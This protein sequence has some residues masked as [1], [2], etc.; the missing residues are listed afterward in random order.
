MGTR[1]E[2]DRHRSGDLPDD[3]FADAVPVVNAA[4]AAANA[5]RG[6]QEA[7]VGALPWLTVP[8]EW[9]GDRP[10]TRTYLLHDAPGPGGFDVRGPGMLPRGKVAMLAAAGGVGKTYALCGL[11]LSLVTRRP[12]LSHFP[13]GEDLRRRV[14][15]VLG[16][17]DPDEVRRRLYTQAHAMGLDPSTHGDDVAGILALPGVGL[18]ALALTRPKEEESTFGPRTAFAEGLRAYLEAHAGTGWDAVILDPLSRFAGPDVEVDN[19]AATRLIQVLEGFTKLPGGP[20]V[21]LAHHTNK[22]SRTVD[23]PTAAT[24]VRG[25]S[26]LVDGARWV[27]NLEDVPLPMG[28][29]LPG[30]ARFRVTKSNYGTFPKSYTADGLLL[31][32]M[33]GGL[34]V[35]NG[36]E[37]TALRT[38]ELE[39]KRIEGEKGAQNKAARAEGGR[40]ASRTSDDGL[41]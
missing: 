27:A 41:A 10:P 17:E 8:P 11:A 2:N 6:K 1:D 16:E 4:E 20:A 22:A 7:A 26:A 14:V 38:A 40:R 34:R 12:W 19:A 33:D 24:A 36:D 18:A 39:A 37:Q 5:E 21:I 35:A 30:H 28:A 3:P 29:K 9:I 25:S 32:R 13:V 15:L 23:T 31:T